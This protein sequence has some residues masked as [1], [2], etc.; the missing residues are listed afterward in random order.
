MDAFRVAIHSFFLSRY[1]YE[2]MI[3]HSF[4]HLFQLVCNVHHDRKAV[5]PLLRLWVDC[6]RPL[7]I[8]LLP[9]KVPLRSLDDPE[10][11][12][13]Q[14]FIERFSEAKG[15]N[16]DG[17]QLGFHDV[18]P[19]RIFVGL[20]FIVVDDQNGSSKHPQAKYVPIPRIRPGDGIDVYITSATR[21]S[22]ETA[23]HLVSFRV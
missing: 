16:I 4:P 12:R 17:L 2:I 5:V 23:K 15:Q 18:L 13:K 21:L 7:E 9:G 6:K 14:S 8:V 20:C 19:L 1:T 10:N 3:F 22:T 11:T